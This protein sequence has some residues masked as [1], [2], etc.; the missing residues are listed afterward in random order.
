MKTTL[1][2]MIALYKKRGHK[3]PERSARAY[4]KGLLTTDKGQLQVP[5]KEIRKIKSKVFN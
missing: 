1:E 2:S 4:L 3:H 5:P